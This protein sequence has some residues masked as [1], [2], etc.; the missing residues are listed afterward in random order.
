LE[1]H[2]Q[3][4]SK[5]SLGFFCHTKHNKNHADAVKVKGGAMH[6]I[7]YVRIVID[8]IGLSFYVVHLPVIITSV[9]INKNPIYYD[10]TM[11]V[12]N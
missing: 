3:H 5:Q 9:V 11:G 6:P 12:S 2:W 8:R 1:K 4:F 10:S 7:N